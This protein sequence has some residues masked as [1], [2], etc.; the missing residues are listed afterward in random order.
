MGSCP[1]WLVFVDSADIEDWQQTINVAD[2]FVFQMGSNR[3]QSIYGDPLG[4]GVFGLLDLFDQ[5]WQ[6][7]LII[8]LELG[9]YVE[10]E[11]DETF[12]KVLMSQELLGPYYLAHLI[13]DLF[14]LFK[15]NVVGAIH[16]NFG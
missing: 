1:D 10:D 8:V 16:D 13:R 5:V 14:E 9:L 7:F 11:R 4:G 6:K 12:Q 15:K 3:V 2:D